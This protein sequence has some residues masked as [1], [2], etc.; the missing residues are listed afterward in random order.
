MPESTMLDFHRE[1]D[2]C[3]FKAIVNLYFFVSSFVEILAKSKVIL[4]KN[5]NI[6]IFASVV[7][8]DSNEPEGA[9]ID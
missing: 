5:D 2:Y 8:K 4:S 7:K 6:P 9:E 1:P 3:F